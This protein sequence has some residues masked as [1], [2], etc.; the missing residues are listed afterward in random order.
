MGLLGGFGDAA[1]KLADKYIDDEIQQQRQKA[2]MMN[3]INQHA[4]TRAID[5]QYAQ[6]KEQRDFDNSVNP[7]R[8][9]ALLDSKI[10]QE[11]VLHKAEVDRTIRDGED[12]NYLS[13][14]DAT[15][16][17]KNS[18][19]YQNSQ[20]DHEDRQKTLQQRD[21]ELGI[22][23]TK[24]RQSLLGDK[25]PKDQVESL[26]KQNDSLKEQSTYANSAEE[27][28]RI[29]AQIEENNAKIRALSSAGF[30]D[31]G[32]GSTSFNSKAASKISDYDPV[33]NDASKETNVPANIIKGFMYVETR[34]KADAVSPTGVQGLMQLTGDTADRFGVTD[35]KDPTQ[36]I[37]GG[38]KYIAE[39][40]NQFSEY[41]DPRFALQSYNSGEGAVK[42]AI[43][44]AKANGDDHTNYDLVRDKYLPTAYKQLVPKGIYDGK[45]A[46]N[47]LAASKSF[48]NEQPQE[49][50]KP[51]AGGLLAPKS[52]KR[53]SKHQDD[54]IDKALGNEDLP[55]PKSVAMKI[56]R[57][58]V[59]NN[60]TDPRDAA[61]MVKDSQPVLDDDKKPT[62]QYVLGDGTIYTP[63]SLLRLKEKA[64]QLKASK[65]ASKSEPSEDSGDG[66]VSQIK[67]KLAENSK[68]RSLLINK[69]L[70]EDK[71]TQVNLSQAEAAKRISDTSGVKFKTFSTR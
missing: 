50:A 18:V 15:G 66:V 10:A 39:L 71:E 31:N 41:K 49:S 32:K 51:E 54:M 28:D 38:A 4:A 34:G 43:A 2:I 42:K 3:N 12:N 52:Q 9:K 44:M 56:A 21:R 36:Q 67:N 14:L 22:E 27:E 35:I 57:E 61:Y 1:G 47:V 70:G 5:D 24:A 60:Q 26:I 64:E 68:A 20:W 17:A 69:M 48:S 59:I 16:K 29:K 37:H 53:T 13:A 25:F 62:G 33:I 40:S 46:D 58:L 63:E 8:Q 11:E 55:L 7:Q 30:S 6:Q 65:S 23:E 19:Q 45:Y